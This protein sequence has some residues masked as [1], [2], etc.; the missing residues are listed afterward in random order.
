MIRKKSENSFDIKKF[1]VSLLYGLFFIYISAAIFYAGGLESANWMLYIFATLVILI[2]YFNDKKK[3]LISYVRMSLMFAIVLTFIDILFSISIITPA[4]YGDILIDI[5]RKFLYSI[6]GAGAYEYLMGFINS[7]DKFFL[8]KN[9]IIA[10]K[11]LAGLIDITHLMFLLLVSDIITTQIQLSGPLFSQIDMM[12]II[13]V[14]IFGYKVTFELIEKRTP[15][16]KL[17]NL[18]L[19]GHPIQIIIRNLHLVV[20]VLMSIPDQLGW[21]IN[22]IYLLFTL[23]ILMFFLGKRFFDLISQTKTLNSSAV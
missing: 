9:G 15:G 20:F 21:W 10:R 4:M 11:F 1:I 7:E 5:V 23:D 3:P 18:K 22:L 19:V 17:L 13:F 6:V 12:I 16:K 8:E 14:I 2:K